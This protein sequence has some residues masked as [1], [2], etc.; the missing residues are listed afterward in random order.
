[1]RDDVDTKSD[2]GDRMK[3]SRRQLSTC[4]SCRHRRIRCD[5]TDRGGETCTGCERK[6]VKCTMTYV[7]ARVEKGRSGR[8]VEQAK[9]LYGVSGPSTVSLP[10]PFHLPVARP[11]LRNTSRPSGTQQLAAALTFDL[12]DAYEKI[13]HPQLPLLDLQSFFTSLRRAHH[14]ISLLSPEDRAVA[15]VMHAWAARF[16]DHPAIIGT[17]NR[18]A[19]PSLRDLLR[20]ATEAV[21]DAGVTRDRFARTLKERALQAVDEAGLMRKATKQNCAVLL[22][23]EALVSWQDEKRQ[24]GRPLLAAAIE[25]LRTLYD[26]SLSSSSS[27][28][29]AVESDPSFW[30]AWLR[31]AVSAALG[32]RLPLLKEEDLAAICPG[33]AELRDEDLEKH[34]HGDAE[35]QDGGR[36]M[37]ALFRHLTNVAREVARLSGPIPRRQGLNF[38]A[39]HRLWQELAR[40]A[41]AT[42]VFVATFASSD[43]G[44]IPFVR[45]L[46][47]CQAQISLALH[48]HL[49]ERLERENVRFGVVDD[50]EEDE[51][52]DALQSTLD[53][54]DVALLRAIQKLIAHAKTYD[55]H[56]VY[57]AVLVA[58]ELPQYLNHLLR[59][60]CDLEGG[61][62]WDVYEKQAALTWFTSALRQVGWCFP[63]RPSLDAAS[64]ALETLHSLCPL[65][66]DNQ[67]SHFFLPSPTLSWAS[68][69]Q[70]G[71][72]SLPPPPPPA[73]SSSGF[74]APSSH[75]SA[76]ADHAPESPVDDF[77]I[78]GPS[79]TVRQS[80]P[81]G[82][83]YP[84]PVVAPAVGGR[85]RASS[86]ASSSISGFGL[87]PIEE[88]E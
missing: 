21:A 20:P 16:I 50:E 1:M 44:S 67:F 18:A 86:I 72:S 32:G 23:L 13:F 5:R 51:Y 53:D 40:S 52:L 57:S 79:T 81:A 88:D 71:L 65:L 34:V 55:T 59:L 73:G 83:F 7:Q 61:T 70:T 35:N 10:R 9:V 15:A 69:P 68:P 11:T 63:V 27:H 66:S 38:D 24:A 76:V 25:H 31:D 80:I 82:S 60:R 46:R 77:S 85:G 37:M 48:R 84:P 39:V 42:A 12:F 3:K 45:D 4:D 64:A 8:L 33:V 58:D 17:G 78:S 75:R 26:S 43:E 41:A 29:P 36:A 56:L 62:V 49:V 87:E 47:A 22:V 30:C 74:V 6:N 2:A 14:D 54:S 19:P 28:D